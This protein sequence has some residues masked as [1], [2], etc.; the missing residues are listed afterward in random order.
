MRSRPL[1]RR[2]RLAVARGALVLAAAALGVLFA[3]GS[4]LAIYLE[5]E[6]FGRPRD[7][8]PRVGY[9]LLL[10]LGFVASVAAPVVLA[11][12]LQR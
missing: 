7:G 12:L 2:R 8:E 10:A 9:L 6:G 3:C 1:A 4:L 5:L 11:R